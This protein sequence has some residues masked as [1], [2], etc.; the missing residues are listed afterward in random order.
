ML[1]LGWLRSWRIIAAGL[2]LAAAGLTGCSALRI[3][4]SQ[5]SEIAYWWLDGYVDFDAEQSVRV[6]EA[7]ARWFTWHRRSELPDYTALLNR[8]A[9]EVLNDT[10]PAATCRWFDDLRRRADTA[11]EQGLPDAA[12]IAASFSNEQLRHLERKQAKNNAEFRNDFL[13]A[14]R[15]ERLARSIERATERAEQLYGRLGERQR[16]RIA[17]GVEASPFDAERWGAERVRRQRDLLRALQQLQGGSTSPAAAEAALRGY[18][19]RVKRSPDETYRRYQEQLETYNCELSAQLHNLTTPE[20]R[21]EAQ[22]RLRGWESD[23]RR[24]STP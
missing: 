22:R 5:S 19:Q 9:T 13:Q 14:D 4:Y 24:L 18:W 15:A 7:I 11:V 12:A 1:K 20:Q 23:L 17:Q 2:L 21:L 8:A 3:V 16:E 10:T 6:R